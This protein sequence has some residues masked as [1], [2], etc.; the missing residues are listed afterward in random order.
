MQ[1]RSRSPRLRH[2]GQRAAK[3]EQRCGERVLRG[4]IREPL[5]P[6]ETAKRREKGER[7]AL[8]PVEQFGQCAGIPTAVVQPVERPCGVMQPGKITGQRA[9]GWR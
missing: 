8:P 6:A 9:S 5:R 4:V 1:S 7:A 3:P 2:P